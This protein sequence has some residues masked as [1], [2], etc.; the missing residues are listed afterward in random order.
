MIAVSPG[1]NGTLPNLIVLKFMVGFFHEN[2]KPK[3]QKKW[4]KEYVKPFF[5]ASL[6]EK[7]KK[8][9]TFYLHAANTDFD[10][11]HLQ[12]EIPPNIAVSD[13]VREL[14]RNSSIC[15]KRSF[16]FIRNIYLEK[17]GIWSVEYFSS[18]VGLNEEQIRR[19][20][21]WQGGKEKPQTTKLF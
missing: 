11:V 17:D 21:E 1:I 2:P 9:P 8:Y 15:L 18:T 10:H 6:Y 14:K 16:K 3:S 4:L 20:T 12:I 13:A 5:I 7:V 19:Y